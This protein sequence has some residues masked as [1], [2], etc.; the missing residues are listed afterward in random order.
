MV[1]GSPRELWGS[2]GIEMKK[3]YF[4]SKNENANRK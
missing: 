2:A 4:Q 3:E 1:D